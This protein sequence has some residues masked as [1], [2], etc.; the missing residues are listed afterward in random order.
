VAAVAAFSA[1]PFQPVG[2]DEAVFILELRRPFLA[3]MQLA[4]AH[5]T[6]PLGFYAGAWLWPHDSLLVARV[7][8]WLP[9]VAVAPVTWL[10]AGRLGLPRL[11]SGLFA[12]SSPFLAWWAADSRMYTWLALFGGVVLLTASSVVT[13]RG[14]VLLGV[15]IGLGLELHY[16][17]FPAGVAALAVLALRGRLRMAAIA[18]A[19]GAVAALPAALALIAE[20]DLLAT[21]Y[22]WQPVLTPYVAL[23]DV[24]S[25]FAGSEDFLPAL[26]AGPLLA[27]LAILGIADRR[28]WSAAAFAAVTLVPALAVSLFAQVFTPRYGA[29]AEPALFLLMAAG[30]AR[31]PAFV[32]RASIAIA[33]AL[34]VS[35]IVRFEVQRPPVETWVDGRVPLVLDA[36]FAPNVAYYYGGRRVDGFERP[37]VDRVGLWALPAATANAGDVFIGYCDE[38]PGSD[39]LRRYPG[40]ECVGRT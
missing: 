18:T 40:N 34:V 20:R 30:A 22:A 1:I 7:L 31:L 32:T 5:E 12:A 28:A 27:L 33:L 23:R 19:V 2:R 21:G 38:T 26:V 8:S 37:R 10:L 16:F 14:A 39:E 3:A 17:A 13:A 24:G 4:M 6:Q 15:L 11:P 9:A 35:G 36:H 29:P 25:L